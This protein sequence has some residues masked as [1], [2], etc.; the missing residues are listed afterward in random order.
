[1]GGISWEGSLMAKYTA[2][3]P[4]MS[5][6]NIHEDVVAALIVPHAVFRPSYMIRLSITLFIEMPI[7][8]YC[9]VYMSLLQYTTWGVAFMLKRVC[10]FIRLVAFYSFQNVGI[11]TNVNLTLENQLI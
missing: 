1:M 5:A 9:I 4:C 2:T 8:N 3:D 6:A 11:F 10:I 7:N